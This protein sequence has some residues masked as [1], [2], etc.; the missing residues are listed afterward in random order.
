MRYLRALAHLTV[1]LVPEYLVVVFVVGSLRGWLFPFDGGA[2]DWALLSVIGAAIVGTVVVIPT[3]G[4]IPI[5]S[6]TAAMAGGVCPT[7]LLGATL[8]T[9]L[10]G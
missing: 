10:G 7:G 8:L 2:T 5:L 9:I 4:E 1:A 6:V 3:A